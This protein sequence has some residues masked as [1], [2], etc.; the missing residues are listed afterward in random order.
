MTTTWQPDTKPQITPTPYC[1]IGEYEPGNGTRYTAVAVPWRAGSTQVMGSMGFVTKG[2]L[3]VS[4]NSA[5]AYLFQEGG[6]LV[7]DTIQEHLGGYD[8]DYPYF[9]DL[10]RALTD[11]DLIHPSGRL[12]DDC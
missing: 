2:W 12:S 10:I 3:V 11:V 4:G 5:R 6:Y 9:G 8:G 1:R 7:D